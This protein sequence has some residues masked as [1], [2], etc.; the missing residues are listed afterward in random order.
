MPTLALEWPE[1]LLSE[2]DRHAEKGEKSVSDFICEEMELRYLHC[3]PDAREAIS[4][5]VRKS[6][7]QYGSKMTC[8]IG[9]KVLAIVAQR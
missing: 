8:G 5:T 7:E 6:R 1:E 9:W 3:L 2:L 4:P